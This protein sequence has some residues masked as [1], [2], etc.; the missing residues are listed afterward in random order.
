MNI[1]A[2]K[3]N[4]EQVQSEGWVVELYADKIEQYV[5]EGARLDGAINDGIKSLLK[6]KAF[7]GKM[8]EVLML[9]TFG[10][11]PV[12]QI[13]L[14]GLGKQNG[15]TRHGLRVTA[16][17]VVN[18]ALKAKVKSLAL[19]YFP[20][21]GMTVSDW[22]QAFVEGAELAAYEA[23]TYR[24]AKT[25][26]F[27]IEQIHIVL[28]GDAADMELEKAQ[29]G[30]LKGKA[31]AD[32]VR[33]AR[34]LTNMPANYL[35]PSLLAEQ[36]VEI[37]KRY[38]MDTHVL[39]EQAIVQKGMGALYAVGKGSIHPPRMAVIKYEG[40]PA[41]TEWLA[42]IGKGITFDTGGYSLKPKD[43]METMF[44]DMGGSAA[45]I[46]AM[47][48]IGQLK[49]KKNIM[50]V[51]PAAENMISREAFKPGDILTS[52]SGKMIEMLNSDAEGRLVL[53]DGVT[54]AKELGATK[55]V[56]VAT[57]TGG[58]LVAFGTVRSGAV[59]NNMDFYHEVEAAS[60]VH[61]ERIWLLPNDDEYKEILKSSIADIKNSTGRH[62]HALMA[63]LFIGEF[64]E[65][66]PWVHLDIAGTAHLNKEHHLG[67]KGAT[68]VMSRTLATLAGCGE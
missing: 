65:D 22:T 30:I 63:G 19:A 16:A 45:V 44:T 39:D 49:P 7:T 13:F 46:G 5:T 29:V 12:K 57:L 34:D 52:Y 31:Y 47:E 28:S 59:T 27:A 66:T 33:I 11:L 32:G 10:L 18:S 26:K 55:I 64:A 56:D 35:I 68:G 42:L 25:T 23:P 24:K 15:F 36:A 17:A 48:T 62:G 37:G 61:D 8:R 60:Q 41:S 6:D 67:P 40:E 43:G 54:Y 14:A 50:A 1:E 51:I 20:I 58:V 2:V 21:E 3:G 4:L 9:P 38:E 53:A